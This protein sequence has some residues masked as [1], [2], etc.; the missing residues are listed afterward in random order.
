MNSDLSP[1]LMSVANLEAWYGESK[2]LHG[3]SFD[4]RPGELLTLLGRNGAGKSTTLKSI[5]GIGRKRRGSVRIDGGELIEK[6][7]RG[8]V[9]HRG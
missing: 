2:A 9:E 1:P 3:A 4:V 7:Q 8:R 5:M 6:R